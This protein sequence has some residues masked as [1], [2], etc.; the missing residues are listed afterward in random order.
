MSYVAKELP[1]KPIVNWTGTTRET[2]IMGSE[3]GAVFQT[4]WDGN[5]LD[6]KVYHLKNS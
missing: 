6:L 5:V 2:F 3:R 1:G 4:L